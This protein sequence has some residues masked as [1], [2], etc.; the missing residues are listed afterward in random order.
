MPSPYSADGSTL[1]ESCRHKDGCFRIGPK[2]RQLKIKSLPLALMILG[3]LTVPRW[4]RP[5]AATGRQGIVTAVR[6]ACP[7]RKL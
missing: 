3:L 1:D 2:G 7:C 6:W 5:S 4:R